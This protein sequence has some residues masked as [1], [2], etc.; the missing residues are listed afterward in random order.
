MTA[1]PPSPHVTAAG[2]LTLRALDGA[3]PFVDEAVAARA[4]AAFARGPWHGLL[5]LGAREVA[6]QLP[7]PFAWLRDFARAFVARLCAL[8]DL[9]ALRADARVPPPPDDELEALAAAV[10]PM[11]GAEY[12]DAELLGRWWES[13]HGP[14]AEA[15]G[16]WQGTAEQW[17]QAQSPLWHRVGRVCFHLAERKG[18]AAAPF[19]FLA[20]YTTGVSAAGRVQHAPLGRAMKEAAETGDRAR[21]ESL[22]EP[23]RRASETVPFVKGLVDAGDIFQPLAWSAA[24]AYAFLKAAP[25]CEAAGVSVRLPD[26]WNPRAPARPAVRVRVG[27]EHRERLSLDALLDFSVELALGDEALTPDDLAVLRAAGTGLVNLRGRWVEVDAKRL[28]ALLAR[29]RDVQRSA[30]D[31]LSVHEALRLLAGAAPAEIDP[32]LVDEGAAAWVRVEPGPWLRDLLRG[33]RDP[34][35]LGDVDPGKA[36][37]AKLRP[38]QEHGLRWLWLLRTVGLGGCLADDMGLGKTLQ[39]IALLAVEKKHQRKA[40]PPSLVVAPASLLAN[41]RAE[42]ARFAPSLRVGTAHPSA[43]AEAPP[44]DGGRWGDGLDVVVTSYGMVARAAWLRERP[45]NV[46]VIDEA[47]AIKNADTKQSR[48]VKSL[49]G[50]A[51]LAL[52]G[53]PVENRLGDLWSLFDFLQPGL[54]GG[55]KAFSRYAKALAGEGSREG[56]GPLRRLVGP[57]I[58]RRLKTDK[59]VIADLP[60]KTEV[61]AWCSLTALQAKLYAEVIADLKRKLSDAA[62]PTT[63]RGAVLASLTRFKQAC[64]HPSQLTGDGRFD[65]GA[66]G[67]YARLRELAEEVAS[68]G[69]KAL[70][71]TQFQEM[72]GPLAALL[73]GVFGAAGVVL[74]G[75]VPVKQRAKLVAAFQSDPNVPFFV[76]SLKAGGTGLTLTAAQHVVHFDRWWNPAVENQA[77]DRAY[78]IGQRRNVMVHRFVCRGTLEEKIDAMLTSKRA[79]ADAVLDAPGGAEVNLTALS[80]DELMKVVSLDLARALDEG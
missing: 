1:A 20:T 71:F 4:L 32:S 72:T 13:L 60:D 23:V 49:R 80:D 29:W 43:G 67:K 66:S 74:D 77:T 42:L 41:W 38:Y 31:G 79:L 51:R 76:L 48:A 7:A 25:D 65:P 54:L 33:L 6:A 3:A 10:P 50:A 30:R 39:V 2:D 68:R 24:R 73:A 5:H 40:A 18:D 78:R 36:L 46:V 64:N 34:G 44:D 17:L 75:K 61:T 14:L 63:R 16:A 12:V 55:A 56:Y 15:L 21:L 45:W 62:D 57:Y 27:A 22:L 52:T 8:P 11:P 37:T 19:A 47:Q 70:V 59:R 58:L 9:E 53:T 28:E 26:W 35:G 69:E